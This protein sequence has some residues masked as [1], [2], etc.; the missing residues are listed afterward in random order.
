VINSEAHVTL[1]GVPYR[2]AEDEEG[3]HYIT[4]EKPLRAPNAQ[5]VQGLTEAQYNID[6]SYLRFVWDDWSQGEAQLKFNPQMPGRS[7]IIQGLNFFGRPG[8]IMM[9]WEGETVL[10]SV[11]GSFSKRVAMA[12]A[13]GGLHAISVGAGS[14]EFHTW[15]DAGGWDA[16]TGSGTTDGARTERCATG[17]ATYFFFQQHGS[18]KIYRTSDGTAWTLLN[19]QTPNNNCQLI[20]L[21]DYLYKFTNQGEVYELSKETVNTTTTEVPILDFSRGTTGVRFDMVAQKIVAADNRVFVM[22]TSGFSTRI[23]EVVPT[24]P[25]ATGF[26]RE[27]I[28]LPDMLGETM[29]WHGGLL[30]WIGRDTEPDG[31]PGMNRSI[32]YYQ[33]GG[34]WGTLGEVRSY[35]DQGISSI[36]T[37]S[38]GGRLNTSA[39]IGTATHDVSLPGVNAGTEALQS[40]TLFEVDAI[41]GGY[42][43]LGAPLDSQV[44]A[45]VPT[46]LIYYK[47][48]YIAQFKDK[49]V[50]ST[51]GAYYWTPHLQG[52]SGFVSS[53]RIDFN[54]AGKKV[55]QEVEITTEPLPA[56]GYIIIY[57]SVNGSTTW[58]QLT[59][60]MT[61]DGDTSYLWSGIST[62]SATVEF[63]YIQFLAF[64]VQPGGSRGRNSPILNSL[65]VRATASVAQKEWQ[66]TLDCTDESSPRGYDGA[67]LMTALRA[68]DSSTVY[69]FQD[70][71]QDRAPGS[72]TSHDVLIEQIMFINDRPGEGAVQLLL[73][74]V[75]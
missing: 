42:G 74:E 7:M 16:G 24:N 64:L 1:N 36:T 50:G 12:T 63:R 60:N 49:A 13:M 34:A 38:G 45:Q 48:S 22:A 31:D 41:S 43:A 23:Y 57:Y 40:L 68:L 65:E 28:N 11:G 37:C 66:I 69:E 30:Y 20:E 56:N 58:T 52:G 9:G 29:W 70:G 47:G 61:T 73:K 17:D 8:S 67:A 35:L 33:P 5:L 14:T 55:L 51:Y 3:E 72:Y 59:P 19:D 39:F 75:L 21:G 54:V 26:G 10:N 44:A 27:I 4:R 71:Y 53:P 15:D 25:S 2:L 18:K 32:Y 6:P 62:D 46:Q